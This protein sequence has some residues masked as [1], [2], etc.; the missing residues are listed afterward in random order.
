M[1]HANDG[2]LIPLLS[3]HRSSA[4]ECVPLAAALDAEQSCSAM[5]SASRGAFVPRTTFAENLESEE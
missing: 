5:T 4:P 2:C 3:A 1:G